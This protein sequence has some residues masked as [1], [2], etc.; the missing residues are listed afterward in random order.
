MSLNRPI[1]ALF[2]FDKMKTVDVVMIVLI[3]SAAA[4]TSRAQQADHRLLLIETH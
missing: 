1:A 4:I 3:A 2:I